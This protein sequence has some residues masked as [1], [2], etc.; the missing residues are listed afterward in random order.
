ME[1]GA[2][3]LRTHYDLI[4]VGTGPAGLTL[5]HKYEQITGNKM[6]MIE[7]GRRSRDKQSCTNT[8]HG[9]RHW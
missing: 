7:S 6:L 1:I 4:V 5:A 3:N 9:D 8:F 2:D